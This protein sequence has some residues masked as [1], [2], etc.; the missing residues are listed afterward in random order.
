MCGIAGIFVP[1]H[2]A[3]PQRGDGAMTAMMDAMHHRGPDGEGRYTS[4]DGR[5]RLGFR[6]LA[7]IDLET[8]D[9]P[10]IDRA[11]RRVLIGNGE[12]Y[13]Y[14]ELRREPEAR[15]YPYRG[16]GD[17]EVVLPLAAAHGDDF[18]DRLN[19]M[20]A[21]A[22]YSEADH[23]LLLVRDR[24]GIKPLYWSPLAGGGLIFAS[25]IKSLFASGLITPGV[26]EASVSAFLGHGFVPAPAT[27]YRHVFKLPPAHTLS[28]NDNGTRDQR[29]YWH[30]QPTEFLPDSPSDIAAHLTALLEDSVAL[31][32]R[33][34][35][36]VGALLS[37]GIDSGLMV[38]LAA[39]Q[40]DRPVRTFTVRFEGSDVDE[41]PLAEAVA[42]RHGAEHRV[43]ELPVASV[44]EHLPG[45]AWMCEEPLSD[46]ALLPNVLIER[47]LA[48]HVTVALNGTGGDELFAGYGRHFRLPVE[49][50]YLRLPRW[51]RRSAAEPLVEAFDPMTAWKLR[52]AEK[53]DRDPGSYLFD[54]GCLFPPPIRR[55]MGN[56]QPLPEP[57]QRAGFADFDGDAQSA[58]LHADLVT[59][60]P[61]DLLTL[62][63]RSSMAASVEGRV[64]FLD[65]R[66][67]TAALAVPPHVRTPGGR[68]KGL[69]RAMAAP[70]LPEA[71]LSA[72][73][74]GFAAPVP[75]WLSAGLG[76]LAQQIL[77]R[78]ASLDRG[79]WTAEGIGRL[80]TEAPGHAF[81]LY[82]LLM[83]EL[84]VRLHVEG[85]A[86]RPDEP[87]QAVADAA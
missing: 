44:G 25:E 41:S 46:A 34:D 10:I 28:V 5:C 61:E 4:P 31:Q 66:L 65:H 9:Q 36:P 64:P 78:P 40:S 63:D 14:R 49:R 30:A 58:S 29:R 26:D 57:A 47:E 60:L 42:R 12:I 37:G 15:D 24:L 56:R 6:R 3:P 67:V 22:L 74:R 35:V 13:N 81:R 80:R 33:S 43:L 70:L 2:A 87:L 82:A 8:G 1:R 86:V 17:M 69:E 75:A 7:I 51:L 85:A 59:Y 39:R 23:R 53:F 48:C 55:L 71:V 45:L 52:R 73:K 68:Q 72:P 79:W 20:F 19:G 11:R 84:T 32:L 77:C 50:R 83:L 21:L 16:R 27:L 38:A 18:I 76:P 54:H 62:L